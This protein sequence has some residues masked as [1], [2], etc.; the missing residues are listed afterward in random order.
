MLPNEEEFLLGPTSKGLPDKLRTEL[1]HA[2]SKKIRTRRKFRQLGGACLLLVTYLAGLGTY[3]LVREAPRPII[4]KEIVY[5]PM[6]EVPVESVAVQAPKEK[7]PQEI[8]MEAELSLETQ[9]SRSFYRQAADKY[10]AR[11]QY[12]QAIR[13]YKCYLVN[14][15]KD[16]LTP[17]SADTWLLASLKTAH[18]T[19]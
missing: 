6:K 10:F 12:E 5:V 15:T 11:N 8:E 4:Q 3:R 1:F 2:T 7:T 17:S 9:E 13:C 14:A 16:D 19:Y 18:A